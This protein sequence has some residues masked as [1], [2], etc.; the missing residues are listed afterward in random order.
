MKHKILHIEDDAILAAVLKRALK[1]VHIE[2]IHAIDGASGLAA[3]EEHQLDLVLLDMEL[4][5]IDG[6]K[7]LKKIRKH[8]SAEKLPVA[9]L[10]GHINANA[11]KHVLQFGVIDV[12]RKP[13]LG[14][15]LA[16]KLERILTTQTQKRND[17]NFEPSLKSKELEIHRLR[18]T[19]NHVQLPSAVCTNCFTILPY[20]A[21]IC[22]ECRALQPEVGWTSLEK[23]EFLLL[24]KTIGR[25]LL[26]RGLNKG[27][28]TRVY[29][30]LDLALQQRVAVKIIDVKPCD[31]FTIESI[32]HDLRTIAT[33]ESP[34]VTKIWDV[35]AVSK[36]SLA[37]VMEFAHGKSLQK[38]IASK[39]PCSPFAAFE[40]AQQVA[41]ALYSS[42]KQ[43]I[44]HQNIK[45]ENIFIERSVSGKFFAKVIELGIAHIINDDYSE[46]FGISA[47]TAPE[48]I[49]NPENVGI[50]TDIYGLA[51]LLYFMLTGEPPFRAVNILEL[52]HEQLSAPILQINDSTVSNREHRT[53]INDL[54]KKAMATAPKDRFTSMLVFSEKLDKIQTVL[55]LTSFSSLSADLE[56]KQTI[57]QKRW[58]NKTMDPTD[59]L[60]LQNEE[61]TRFAEDEWEDTSSSVITNHG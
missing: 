9:I 24:G 23:T 58:L 16:H 19:Q 28:K 4:P 55:N 41:D 54:L 57:F 53:L 34:N 13:I 35:I 33:I 14:R 27:V 42:H 8:F 11:I 36:T 47:F 61:N 52:L 50:Q 25:Y 29:R 5:D 60:S 26:E 1:E 17:Y 15:L 10:S 59:L 37:I 21:L 39:G 45:P 3:L 30:G 46:Q 32:K 43:G 56:E 40:I 31:T 48:Q 22:L 51:G 38:I 49:L 12:L 6:G 44:L 18:F 2:V 20:D 7:L